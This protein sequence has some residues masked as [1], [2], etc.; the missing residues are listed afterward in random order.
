MMLKWRIFLFKGIFLQL[1]KHS[2]LSQNIKISNIK[3]ANYQP[4]MWTDNRVNFLVDERRR[5]DAY[6]SAYGRTRMEF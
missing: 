3:M 6:H 1:S 2:I 4:I 5:K